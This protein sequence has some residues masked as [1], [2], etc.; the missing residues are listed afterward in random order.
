MKIKKYYEGCEND[1]LDSDNFYDKIVICNHYQGCEDK[2]CP[3][4]KPHFLYISGY[5]NSCTAVECYA[6]VFETECI[7]I[8]FFNINLTK[9]EK[10][11]LY[12]A[13]ER[14]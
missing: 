5:S 14:M 12:T 9:E 6:A 3:H 2:E 11:D 10:D 13:S 1:N 8:E 4:H 7:E